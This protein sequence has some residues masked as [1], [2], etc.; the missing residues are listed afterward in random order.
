MSEESLPELF[1]NLSDEEHAEVAF[2]MRRYFEYILRLQRSIGADPARQEK[3]EKEL[4]ALQKKRRPRKRKP[5]P[6]EGGVG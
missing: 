5:T 2:Q 3:F 1:P 4:L 6:P